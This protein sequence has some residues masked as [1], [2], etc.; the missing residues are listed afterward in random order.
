VVVLVGAA[1]AGEKGAYKPPLLRVEEG[2]GGLR[3]AWRQ[4]E[5]GTWGMALYAPGWRVAKPL[6]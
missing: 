1:R 3:G 2:E 5:G 4:M 6:I